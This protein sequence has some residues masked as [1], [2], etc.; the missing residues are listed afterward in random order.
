[1]IYCKENCFKKT[2][3]NLNYHMNNWW[4]ELKINYF[5]LHLGKQKVNER[6]IMKSRE[7][8]EPFII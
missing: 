2:L 3:L 8:S 1:M 7:N 5:E 4:R 6:K